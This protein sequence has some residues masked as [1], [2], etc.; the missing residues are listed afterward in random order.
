[1]VP[2]NG[3]APGYLSSPG[4]APSTTS[5]NERD[6]KMAVKVTKDGNTIKFYPDAGDSDLAHYLNGLVNEARSLTATADPGTLAKS[7]LTGVAYVR[8]AQEEKIQALKEL[9]DREENKS[10]DWNLNYDLRRLANQR[11]YAAK[12]E[13]RQLTAELGQ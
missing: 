6:V 5:T 8:K 11:H 4:A 12:E 3:A 10:L 13:I 9:A 1:M 2:G 7:G